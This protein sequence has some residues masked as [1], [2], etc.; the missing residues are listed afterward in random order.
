MEQPNTRHYRFAGFAL[1]TLA[2]ELKAADGGVVPLNARAFDALCLLLRHRDRVVGKDELL[3]QVWAGRVVEENTLTQAISGLRRALGSGAGDHRYILTVPGRGYRFVAEVEEGDPATPRLRRASDQDAPPGADADPPPPA[4][5]GVV[6]PA[7]GRRAWWLGALALSLAVLA[8]AAWRGGTLHPPVPLA[9]VPIT[10]EARAPDVTLAVL[11][12][13]SLSGGP[14]DEGLELGMADTLIT[15][16]S[17]TGGLQVRALSSSQRVASF[18][19][20]AR[21]VGRALGAAYLVEGTTQRAG[22]QVR[23][24]ARLLSAEDGKAIWADTFDAPMARVF[25]VQDRVGEAVTAALNLSP[26]LVPQ[27]GQSPCD[28]ADPRAYRAVLRGQYQNN[29]PS[30]GRTAEALAAF[31]EAI[32]RDPT[33]ARA[34][35]GMAFAYRAMVMT[36]DGDPRQLFPLAKAAVQKALA[37]DPQSAEAWSSKGFIE[38]WYDWDWP[39]AESSIR[40]AIALNPNLPE[41][42]LAMAHL[43][44][45]IGRAQEALPYARRA[46]ALDP[47]SPL[48]NSLGSFFMRIAGQQEES[49]KHLRKTLELEPDAWIALRLT[50]AQAM[51]RGDSG[52]AIASLRRAVE[53]SDGHSNTVAMLGLAYLKAGDRAAAERLLADLE[54]RR[55]RGYVPV[56]SLAMLTDALGER[57]RTLDLLEQGYRERDIRMSFLSLDWPQLRTEPRYLALLDRLRLPPPALSAQA[58]A[59][60]GP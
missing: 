4:S 37:I 27:R 24:N 42:Q 57:A 11:P 33:C 50:A 53:I 6:P 60:R 13:R 39:R 3:E 40:R 35:A 31:R 26:A 36:G 38:F 15:R 1:D 22:D 46:I 56:T 17:R 21:A 30:A 54:A 41:A 51:A 12:F 2:R 25:T 10:A 58:R 55:R 14:R 28:G 8:F 5:P 49:Q 52:T 16:L 43:L 9:A 19:L 48:I 45:N 59:A 29:R 32:D 34:W 23:V 20:D 47:L 18:P 44:A 7:H